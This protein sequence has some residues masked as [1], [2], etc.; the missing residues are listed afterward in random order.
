[1]L[2]PTEVNAKVLDKLQDGQA[3]LDQS[4]ASVGPRAKEKVSEGDI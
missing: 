2:G 3:C 4:M 1:M